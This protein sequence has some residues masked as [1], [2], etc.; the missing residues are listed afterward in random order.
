MATLT[1]KDNIEMYLKVRKAFRTGRSHHNKE[2]QKI[3]QEIY[4]EF[5]VSR[6]AMVSH[7]DGVIEM[8]KKQ[9]KGERYIDIL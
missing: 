2:A 3:L 7:L 6:K 9:I 1:I 8:R 4:D 5:G